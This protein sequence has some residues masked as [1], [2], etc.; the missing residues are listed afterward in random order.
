MDSKAILVTAIRQIKG[1]D[2]AAPGPGVDLVYDL[3]LDSIEFAELFFKLEHE[4][5]VELEY[6]DLKRLCRNKRKNKEL[7]IFFEDVLEYIASIKP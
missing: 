1:E 4:L 7:K 2:S 5:N 3:C 6:S